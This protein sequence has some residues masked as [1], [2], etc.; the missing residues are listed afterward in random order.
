MYSDTSGAP[1]YIAGGN[2]YVCDRCCQKRRRSMIA[3]EWTNLMVCRDTCLDPVP[4][5]MTPPRVWPEGLPVPNA[6]PV[7]PYIFITSPIELFGFD[8]DVLTGFD[9]EQLEPAP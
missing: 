1:A 8:G 3:R 7:P 6:R 9:G 5:E 4:P 2:Y